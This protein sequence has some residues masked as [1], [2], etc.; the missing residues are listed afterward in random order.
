MPEKT[1]KRNMEGHKDGG[2]WKALR[3]NTRRV[4]VE[5]SMKKH[6]DGR[7]KEGHKERFT[8]KNTR[9]NTQKTHGLFFSDPQLLQRP[10]F[11]SIRVAFA[12]LSDHSFT[13]SILH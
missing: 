4:Q 6:I 3:R 9:R 12:Y 1:L 5:L 8:K 11:Y 13:P 2:K 7:H 10:S